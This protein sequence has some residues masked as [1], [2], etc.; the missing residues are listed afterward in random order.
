M[1]DKKIEAK[2][3]FGHRVFSKKDVVLLSPEVL[4]FS[5][6]SNDNDFFMSFIIFSLFFS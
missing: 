3:L 6:T 1:D 5:S 2:T 4:N